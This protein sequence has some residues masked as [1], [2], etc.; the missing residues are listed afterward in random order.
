[1]TDVQ[2]YQ[3]PKVMEAIRLYTDPLLPTFGV[4]SSSAAQAGAHSSIFQRQDVKDEVQRIVQQRYAASTRVVEYL[5]TYTMDAAHELI[6]QLS[7]GRDLEFKE[8]DEAIEN[9]DDKMGAV[10]VRHNKTVIEA[11]KE[12]RAAA[13]E[14]I[15]QQIGTPEHRVRVQDD[16]KDPID[17]EHLSDDELKQLGEIIWDTLEDRKPTEAEVEIV[18]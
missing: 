11:A 1:M 3:D 4:K 8:I 9:S 16:R 15:R 10:I 6:K 14:I 5:A 2:L 12:R 17:L 13:I 7:T 18:G